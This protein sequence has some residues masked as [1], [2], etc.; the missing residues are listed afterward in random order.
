MKSIF[1]ILLFISF[2]VRPL[3]FTGYVAYFQLNIDYIIETYCINKEKPQLQCNGKCHLAKQL[4][5]ATTTTNDN[6]I[7][8]AL[9]TLAESFFPVF[10]ADY[11][12]NNLKSN[13][14]LNLFQVEPA[15]QNLYDYSFES[16]SFK[17]P[18]V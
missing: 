12:Y 13:S 15:Y 8:L 18:I 5:T 7:D 10:F 4:A 11:N 16:F 17:P 1:A 9:N 14:L 3:F 2:A 6:D